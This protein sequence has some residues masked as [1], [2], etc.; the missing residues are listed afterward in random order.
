MK[1][2]LATATIYERNG[3][4]LVYPSSQTTTGLWMTDTPSIKM[5]SK[6]S[7]EEI[8]KAV[9]SALDGSR[10][11]VEHPKSRESFARH[12]E[13]LLQDAGVKSWSTFVRSARAVDVARDEVQLEVMAW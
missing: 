11:G 2:A 13:A 8:G 1:Q 9:L 10:I 4:L 7:P 12:T 3:M 6:A 5:P